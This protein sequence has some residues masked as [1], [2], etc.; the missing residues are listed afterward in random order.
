M[1]S[2][3]EVTAVQQRA[4]G[5]SIKGDLAVIGPAATPE[6]ASGVSV[7]RELSTSGARACRSDRRTQRHGALHPGTA[8]EDPRQ[9]A[10]LVHSPDFA[11]PTVFPAR[12]RD[13]PRCPRNPDLFTTC[14]RAAE[15]K[16]S[17]P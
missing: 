2:P 11:R 5:G 7:L 17:V 14:T 10:D 4:R 3:V 15:P 1:R 9:T 16:G 12:E 6:G 13:Q 8:A